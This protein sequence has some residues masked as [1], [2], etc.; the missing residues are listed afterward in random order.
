[1]ECAS[2]H[3]FLMKGANVLNV[4]K[5]LLTLAAAT[6][7]AVPA[8]ADTVDVLSDGN[9]DQSPVY[10]GW[11]FGGS[12][13][14]W[15][16]SRLLVSDPSDYYVQ[17]RATGGRDSYMTQTFSTVAG[18]TYTLSFDYISVFGATQFGLQDGDANS[19]TWI[20]YED[21]AHSASRTTWDTYTYTFTA[22]SDVTTVGFVT[23]SAG[24]RL[25]LN[26]ISVAAAVPEPASMALFMAGLGALGFVSRRRR[27]K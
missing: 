19:S 23:A 6:L 9:L 24:A 13:Y 21:L 8:F 16:N 10:N 18:T 2:A 27:V 12:S 17:L 1:M 7:L 4:K 5:S 26:N 15:N 11:D 14:T 20:D 25:F 3:F 22:L